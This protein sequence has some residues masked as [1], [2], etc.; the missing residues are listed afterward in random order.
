MQNPEPITLKDGRRAF[1]GLC[2]RCG[3]LFYKVMPEDVP[4]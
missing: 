3:T 2:A 1:K 4:N